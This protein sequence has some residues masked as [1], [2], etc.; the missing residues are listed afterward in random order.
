MKKIIIL[1]SLAAFLTVSAAPVFAITG[2]NAV[3]IVNFDDKPGKK[4]KKENN[5]NESADNKSSS[6]SEKS[7]QCEGDKST[8]CCEKSKQCEDKK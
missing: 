5:K 4:D 3:E 1:F 2:S 8:S 6:C 7:R